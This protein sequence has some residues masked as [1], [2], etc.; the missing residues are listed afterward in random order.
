[1]DALTMRQTILEFPDQS[2]WLNVS[3]YSEN[4]IL[5]LMLILG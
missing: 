1:V 3:A 2:G 5:K 4:I